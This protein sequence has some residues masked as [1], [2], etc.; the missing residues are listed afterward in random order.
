MFLQ[1]SKIQTVGN[2]KKEKKSVNLFQKILIIH[3]YVSSENVQCF[4]RA[5]L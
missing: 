2:Q 4:I 5:F 3:I 1:K